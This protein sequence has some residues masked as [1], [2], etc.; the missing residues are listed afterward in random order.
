MRRNS[1]VSPVGRLFRLVEGAGGSLFCGKNVFNSQYSPGGSFNAIFPDLGYLYR[2]GRISEYC[3][4]C[5]PQQYGISSDGFLCCIE[6]LRCMFYGVDAIL[7]DIGESYIHNGCPLGSAPCMSSGIDT[8]GGR[9]IHEGTH[10][11]VGVLVWVP[12]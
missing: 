8:K 9:S 4:G 12:H 1:T 11:G 7:W 3:N 2:D 10:Q 5:M 6:H